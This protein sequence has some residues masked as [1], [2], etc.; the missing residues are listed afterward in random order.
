MSDDV[1]TAI[2]KAI[3]HIDLVI[4]LANLIILGFNIKLYTE[5]FKDKSADKRGNNG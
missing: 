1:L 5:Y 3:I 2:I 4:L